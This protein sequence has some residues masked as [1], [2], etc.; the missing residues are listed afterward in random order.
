MTHA[1]VFVGFDRDPADPDNKVCVIVRCRCANCLCLNPRCGVVGR[2][3]LHGRSKTAG[4]KKGML[5]GRHAA[6]M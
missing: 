5:P 6:N 2:R 4:A 1:M 3:L